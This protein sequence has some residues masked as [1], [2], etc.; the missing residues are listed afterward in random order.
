MPLESVP[1]IG[2]A[3]IAGVVL[4]AGLLFAQWLSRSASWAPAGPISLIAAGPLLPH[5]PLISS[6]SA[7]DLLPL[8]GVAMLVWRQPVPTL[9]RSRLVRWTLAAVAVATLARVA[10]A[11]VNGG[12][13][14]GT[15]TMLAQAIGRPLV[16]VAIATY[17]AV[18]APEGHRLRWIALSVGVIGTFEAAFGMLGFAVGLPGGAGIEAARPFSSL[19][20]VCPGRITGTLGLSANH[21]GAVFV[22]S[23]PMTLALAVSSAR[24]RRWGWVA[25]AAIQGAALVLTFTRS[26]ILIGIIISVGFLLLQRRVLM[27]AV[28]TAVATAILASAFTLSCAGAPLG[29][30]IAERSDRLALWYAAGLMMLDHPLVGVG[31]DRMF[32]EVRANPER[33]RETPFGRATN[34]AHNT[35]LLA[36]AETGVFGGLGVLGINL[37]LGLIALRRA[38]RALLRQHAL[39][40][41]AA[42]TLVGYLG[43]GMVNNLFSVPATSV[44]FALVVGAVV[45]APGGGEDRPYTSRTPD[46]HGLDGEH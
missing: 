23:L 1:L 12:G 35:I 11:L 17:V 26:S 3:A 5:V 15:L 42:L 37:G 28:V 8:V 39:A 36:A 22:L 40:L 29:E 4:L 32:D 19:Y 44:V 31:L 46:D 21:I 7:D 38:W 20:G 25:A 14:D 34:T 30:R 33:Y 18:A 9:S 43:Q 10:T 16:L 24:W 45:G 2:R 27:L 6:V 13:L 41:A